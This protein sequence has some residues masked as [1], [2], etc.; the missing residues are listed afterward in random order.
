MEK[1]VDRVRC[2]R[3]RQKAEGKT[4]ITVLLSQEARVF[5]AEEKEKNG[6]SY[7]VIVEK[8]IQTLKRHGRHR[9]PALTHISKGEEGRARMSMRDHQP[10]VIPLT[11]QENRG[12]PQ[13]LIDDLAN[14][15]NIKNIEREQA[16]ID[17]NG[18]YDLKSK[19]GLI[20]RLLRSSVSPFTHKKKWF[21]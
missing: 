7:A 4:S 3:E 9:A 13:V 19:E 1:K 17:R 2:W 8:A 12:Q 15:P 18:I 6:E 10:S 5:L 11:G 14:Y 21:R 16:G 20:T